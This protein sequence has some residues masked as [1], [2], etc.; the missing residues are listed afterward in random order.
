[1]AKIIRNINL[2]VKELLAGE[3]VALPTETVYGLAVN[4]LD[5]ESVL[6]IFT[7]KK[8][9]HFDPLIVH[10]SDIS[11]INKFAKYIPDD[12]FLLAEQFSPG[13][14]T[15]VVKKRNLIP[16]LVTAG[17]DTVAIRIPSHT[18][19]RKVLQNLPFPLAAP[20]ANMFGRISPTSAEEV[21]KE[22][23]GKINFILDGG[24]SRI[25]I[26]STVIAFKNNNAVILRPGFITKDKIEKVLKRKVE[27]F[28]NKISQ[29]V[30]SPG[31]LKIHYSP[32]TPLYL[33]NDNFNI[34]ILN[35]LNAVYLDLNKFSNLNELA[36]D[37]FSEIR[38]LDE[39]KYNFIVTKKTDNEGLGYA[40]N[41]RLEKAS[42]GKIRFSDNK[43]IIT[44]K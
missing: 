30:S 3:A 20:S 29:N 9:P 18:L 22:L 1:M 5:A 10:I 16:D 31:A 36:S 2:A 38:K 23:N 4:A 13:P 41:D 32:M 11:E 7:I 21:K 6:K 35:K 34:N 24:K 19:F 42:H 26:E 8:R 12:V 43:P 17:L 14:I 37:L 40:I 44:K 33:C 39:K 28:S 27:Y 15:F 25:G